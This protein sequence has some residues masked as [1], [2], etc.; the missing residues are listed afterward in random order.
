VRSSSQG[1][2]SSGPASGGVNWLGRVDSRITGASVGAGQIA[3]MWTAGPDSSHPFPYIRAVRV[4]ET[5]KSLVDEP[6]IW[7][8]NGAWAYPA[9]GTNSAGQ[10]GIS[11]FYGG[12]AGH[13][14]A[15]V[16]GIRTASAWS[17]ARTATSTNDPSSPAWGDYLSCIAHTPNAAH[18]AASG[19]T[20]QG[21][22]A[23]TN[24]VPRYIEFSP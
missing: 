1:P 23:R 21:G 19:Y 24:A 11:A 8:Q 2:Y 4:N 9:A 13:H 22:A 15:H 20:M 5:T 6:D 18:W 14:P 17:T 3:F 12:L 10:I 7:S 16:V